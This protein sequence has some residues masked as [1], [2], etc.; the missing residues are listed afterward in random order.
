MPELALKENPDNKS[1]K[2]KAQCP[3]CPKT[4]KEI[5][6]KFAGKYRISKYEC[7]HTV[8]RVVEKT[9]IEQEQIEN[10]YRDYTSHIRGHKLREFQ[11]EDVLKGEKTPGIFLLGHEMGLGKTPMSLVYMTRH[12]EKFPCLIICKSVVKAQWYKQILEWCGKDYALTQIIDKGFSIPLVTQPAM[13]GANWKFTIVSFDMLRRL[14]WD[15]KIFSHFKTMI[16]DEVQHI[17]NPS[18]WR[19]ALV[20]KAAKSIRNIIGASGTSVKNH[21]GEFFTILNIMYP[22]RF[23]D[24]KKYLYDYCDTYFDGRNTKVGGIR[25]DRQERFKQLTDDFVFRRLRAE[26]MPE[27]PLIDRQFMWSELGDDVEKAYNKQLE[28]FITEYDK[29]GGVTQKNFTNLLGYINTMRQLCG[30]AKV[31]PVVNYIAEFLLSTNEK[32]TIFTH[33]DSVTYTLQK[34]LAEICAEGGFAE[35]LLYQAKGKQTEQEQEK[36]KQKFIEDP[37]YRILIASTLATGEGVDGLQFSC[38]KMIMMERQW[39]P[40]NE[41]QCE[42]RFP[43]PGATAQSILAAY[44]CAGGTIDE[45]FTEIVERKRSHMQSTLDGKD[46]K[47]DEQSLMKELMNTLAEKGRSSITP[48]KKLAGKR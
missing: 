9:E 15:E 14:D 6:I 42:A 44:F 31:E 30:I 34:R 16:I 11:Y 36:N 43:R 12:P 7:G 1:R 28:E 23:P 26:V 47:F 35:P 32:I 3:Y 2:L 46:T 25:A 10:Y 40:A 20:K 37:R 39:N 17:K 24:Y 48:Q 13:G 33:H 5:E 29:S 27:L 41:E 19:A 22:E 8:S 38:S 18:T 21:A 4:A 45:W